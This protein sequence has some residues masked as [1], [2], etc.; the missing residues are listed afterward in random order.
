MD[1]SIS[2]AK[3][4]TYLFTGLG[5]LGLIVG[6]FLPWVQT[7]SL[8]ENE[9]AI[10][11]GVLTSGFGIVV[12]ILGLLVIGTLTKS[13]FNIPNQVWAGILGFTGL[14][15]TLAYILDNS[16]DLKIGIWIAF[17]ASIL[18]V[19]KMLGDAFSG[20]FKSGES[21]KELSV[22]NTQNILGLAIP[23]LIALLFFPYVSLFVLPGI[24]L[25]P[26]KL[27]DLYEAT[28]IITAILLILLIV[29]TLLAQI[30]K[31]IKIP[32]ALPLKL[33]TPLLAIHSTFIFRMLS[34]DNNIGA[35]AA[36]WVIFITSLFI[37]LIAA[38][39]FKESSTGM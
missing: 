14:L 18:L 37:F 30:S 31:S 16:G 11:V 13:P 23:A 17:A 19:L 36:N 34:S 9:D 32:A 38:R 21:K 6:S 4:L 10:G 27:L 5:G 24:A 12:F 8:I 3:R 28:G 29:S 22:C 25:R 20:A 39:S 1:T 35:G 7:N 2:S 15:L 33:S 26:E